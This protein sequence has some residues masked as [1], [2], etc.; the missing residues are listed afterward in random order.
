M[1]PKD[2][3]RILIVDDEPANRD[4]Y[5]LALQDEN[6]NWQIFQAKGRVEA[7]QLLATQLEKREPV[8]VILTDLVM[9]SEESGMD[10]IE[11]AHR[12]D[13]L[14]M[15]VLF[16]G[17][18]HMLDRYRA[19]ELGAFDV[20]D[21]GIPGVSPVREINIKARAALL[22]REQAG[23]MLFLR[24][25]FDPRVFSTIE[26]E[27]ALLEARQRQITIAFWDIREF[28]LL[29]EILKAHPALIAGF[30]RDY[31]DV[32]ARTIFEHNGLLDKFI[33]D[34]V[35]ALFGVLNHRNDQG[36]ADAMAAV[37]AAQDL[38][39]RFKEVY[40]RW[41]EKW[42]LHA[43]QKIEIGLGCGIHTGEALVGNVGTE[44]RDQFT[45]LGPH[46]NFASR[47]EGES[48]GGEIIISQTTEARVRGSVA[49]EPAGVIDKIKNIPGTFELF[50]V[51]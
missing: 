30:L 18:G 37:R 29:C 45:A 6:P 14:V 2:R 5:A 9:E 27:P 41:L 4:A 51:R 32:A 16:T 21:K 39:I 24:R 42:T 26:N 3:P 15:V 12:L 11:E 28:S 34:G 40:Q 47:I 43:P 44:F 19:F 1:N 50:K 48:K 49:L 20:V 22:F 36:K 25:Y 10:L 46:V 33:G 38:R 23:R 7:L 35:M 13:P 8:D 17:K 31:C